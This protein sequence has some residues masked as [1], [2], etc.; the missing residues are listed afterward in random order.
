MKRCPHC[1]FVYEDDQAVCDMDGKELV[2]ESRW[3]PL[4]VTAAT[5]PPPPPRSRWRSLALL[6]V[7]GGVLAGV[8]CVDY[9]NFKHPTKSRTV[10]SKSEMLSPSS[11]MPA[12]KS[13]TGN[14]RIETSNRNSAPNP[15]ALPPAIRRSKRE[16]SETATP[17]PS[18]S[19]SDS[20]PTKSVSPRAKSTELRAPTPKPRT[21]AT[22]LRPPEPHARVVKTVESR[23]NFDITDQKAA[24]PDQKK[25]SKLGSFLKKTGRILKKPFRF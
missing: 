20:V 7:A 18:K 21:P 4:P 14:S 12:T 17:S 6:V 19:S 10:S 22:E 9:Y 5:E 25:Q 11:E 1:Q 23:P 3:F 2:R 24:N 15:A 16:T 13:E 8:L